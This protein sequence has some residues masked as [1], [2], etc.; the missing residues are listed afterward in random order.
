MYQD[1]FIAITWIVSPLIPFSFQESS[2]TD[3]Q[4][5][6]EIRKLTV[7]VGSDLKLAPLESISVPQIEI[8]GEVDKPKLKKMCNDLLKKYEKGTYCSLL[9][10]Y[11]LYHEYV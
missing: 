4:I 6:E 7:K 9:S 8:T 2:L 5:F 1:I 3:K 10:M 11:Q